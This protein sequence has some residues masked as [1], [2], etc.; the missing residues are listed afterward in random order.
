[1]TDEAIDVRPSGGELVHGGLALCDVCGLLFPH[2]SAR[3][4]HIVKT[5][6]VIR[7]PKDYSLFHRSSLQA[8]KGNRRFFCPM[9]T[10]TYFDGVWFNTLRQLKQHYQKVKAFVNSRAVCCL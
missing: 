2:T 8:V 5:H 7:N 3:Q 6:R 1:M 9:K 10:C 4:L